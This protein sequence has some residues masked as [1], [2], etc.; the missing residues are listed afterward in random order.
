M[1][2]RASEPMRILVVTAMYPTTANPVW[3]IVVAREVEALRA[4][5]HEVRALTKRPGA[6]GYLRQWWDATREVRRWRP[7]VVHAHFGT[8]AFVAA[9]LP[10]RTRLVVTLHGSDVTYGPGLTW[11]RHWLQYWMSVLAACRASAVVVQAEFM[12]RRLIRPV[13]RKA[14][15]LPQPVDLTR[16]GADQRSVR[17]P[18]MVLF[19]GDSKRAVKRRALADEAWSLLPSP[20]PTLTGLDALAPKDIPSAMSRARV[21]VLTSEREGLPV[22]CR[23]ALVSG[24]PV[25]AVELPGTRELAEQLP[26]GVL[27]TSQ[28][29]AA[30]ADAVSRALTATEGAS[31]AALSGRLRDAA[32]ALGWGAA[33]HLDAVVALYRG[34]H[35]GE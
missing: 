13:R 29:P 14:V 34:P 15:V 3:G 28:E 4:A 27:L 26:E 25:V 9:L 23:E 24:L 35:R 12:R 18:G 32:R 20:R 10:S 30:I 2:D 5:G 16:F 17:D 33:G 7:D 22:A 21:G 8:S 19:L 31:G 11:D 1:G 6:L